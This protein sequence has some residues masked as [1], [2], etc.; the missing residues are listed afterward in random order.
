MSSSVPGRQIKR[1]ETNLVYAIGMK[2][3]ATGT[4]R[5]ADAVA[6]LRSRQ[7]GRV[8]VAS[9]LLSEGLFQDRLRAS[10]ADVVTEPLGTHPGLVRLIANRFRRALVPM[11]A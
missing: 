8:A 9:Y 7:H 4:P 11:A 1:K 10:G 3:A 6:A 5:V 2:F